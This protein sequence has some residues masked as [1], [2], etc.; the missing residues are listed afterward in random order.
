MA[1]GIAMG[2][3]KGHILTKIEKKSNE[4]IIRPRKRMKIVRSIVHEISG[5]APYERKIMELLKQNKRITDK[6][7]YKLAKK[8]LGTHKRALRK[9][10][11]LKDAVAH[12]EK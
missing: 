11:E 12:H 9:R 5:H 8:S 10:N 6:K 1:K 4:K 2:N 7:A 3:D